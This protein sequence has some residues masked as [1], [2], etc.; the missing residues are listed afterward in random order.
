MRR[1]ANV[2]STAPSSRHHGTVRIIAGSNK[3][4]RIFAPK[5]HDT[6]PTSDRAR[7][8]AFNLIGPVDDSSVLDLFAGSGAMGLEALSRGAA[9]VVFVEND[10]DACRAIDRNLDKL[11]L[12]GARVIQ[13]D[14]LRALA[15]EAAAG[16]RYDLVLVDPPYQ[17]FSSLQ[18]RLST[19][20]PA[21]LADDG[22]IVL[23]TG[24]RDEPDLPPLSKRTS[25]RYGAARITLF[26]K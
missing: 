11:R 23:E 19:Y 2:S 15:G 14:A 7:E 3:G 9:S 6:R 17:M 8:A 25:R 22:L 18:K 20:L 26:E 4:A 13:Q 21:V 1:N 10:R 12:T 16:H 24:A 5:G